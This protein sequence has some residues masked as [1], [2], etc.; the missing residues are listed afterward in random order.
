MK[1]ASKTE[2]A[3]VRRNSGEPAAMSRDPKEKGGGRME[4]TRF[5]AMHS[6]PRFRRF[7]KNA[8]KVEIDSRFAGMFTDKSFQVWQGLD[9]IV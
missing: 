1:G 3:N 9:G 5:A 7:P 2:G 6:D 4:D 8:T